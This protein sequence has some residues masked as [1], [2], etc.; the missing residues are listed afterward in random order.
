M[1]EANENVKKAE[2]KANEL[3]QVVEH[4]K[5]LRR[6][7]EKELDELKK[8]TEK[9]NNDLLEVMKAKDDLHAEILKLEI[10][11][12]SME[13]KMGSLDSSQDCLSIEMT[14]LEQILN[15]SLNSEEVDR[16]KSEIEKRKMVKSTTD[17]VESATSDKEAQMKSEYERAYK[18]GNKL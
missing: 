12:N 8:L 1:D 7:K 4:E 9:Q 2:D 3:S 16:V 18:V 11:K 13:E 17:S 15:R 10:E 14:F 5:Y 6:E